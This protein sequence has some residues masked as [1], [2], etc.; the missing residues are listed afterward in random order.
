VLR[1]ATEAK[2]GVLATLMIRPERITVLATEP[3]GDA[4]RLAATVSDLT[5]QGPLVRAAA[6]A[7]DGS[8]VVAHIGPEDDLPALRPGSSVWLTWDHDAARLLPGRDPR[9]GATEEID[10]IEKIRF[11]TTEA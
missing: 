5:F 2:V 3:P 7:A 10:E 6:R 4:A 9:H 11:T 1:G 8:E